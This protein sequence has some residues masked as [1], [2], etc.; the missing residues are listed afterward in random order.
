MSDRLTCVSPPAKGSRQARRARRAR[1]ASHS[2]HGTYAF[3]VQS[4]PKRFSAIAT[5][6]AV[7]PHVDWECV[8]RHFNSAN[9]GAPPMQPH[10]STASA[11]PPAAPAPQ[12]RAQPAAV[13]ETLAPAEP[14]PM[15]EALIQQLME[16]GF[17]RDQCEPALRAAFGNPDRA[18][19]YLMTVCTGAVVS[20][21]PLRFQ[22]NVCKPM[23]ATGHRTSLSR[24]YPTEPRG[25]RIQG[26]PDNLREVASNPTPLRRAPSARSQEP[27]V[28]I[29]QSSPAAAALGWGVSGRCLRS[30]VV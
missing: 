11:Q 17:P 4:L 16:M 1:A 10:Q 26:I 14:D 18:V 6:T 25:L 23:T 12:P 8:Q 3:S 9:H 15:T 20:R 5:N 29:D 24:S 19:E 27:G 2:S 30:R 21:M 28:Y 7:Y 22:K 13:T